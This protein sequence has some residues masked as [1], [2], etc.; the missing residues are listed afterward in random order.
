MEYH[1]TAQKYK[2]FDTLPIRALWCAVIDQA[3][4][5]ATSISKY[6]CSSRNNQREMDAGT[7]I[8]WIKSNDFTLVCECLN[9]DPEP[10]RVKAL[11]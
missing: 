7:A 8:A 3:Y 10:I 5:D 2:D 6:K 1:F 9:I 4:E 11:S